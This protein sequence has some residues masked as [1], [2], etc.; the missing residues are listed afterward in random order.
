MSLKYKKQTAQICE[1]F[2]LQG[3]S[4]VLHKNYY[5]IWI[6]VFP[7]LGVDCLAEKLA[8]KFCYTEIVKKN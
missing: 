4:T 2:S 5:T 8:K 1:F 6:L 7:F 3:H